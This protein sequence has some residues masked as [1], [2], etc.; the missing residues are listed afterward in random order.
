MLSTKALRFAPRAARNLTTRRFMSAQAATRTS[1][2]HATNP[3]LSFYTKR[4]GNTLTLVVPGA[5]FLAWPFIT[6]AV[7]MKTGI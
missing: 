6:R 1:D 5:V 3:K 2:P 7:L 4:M